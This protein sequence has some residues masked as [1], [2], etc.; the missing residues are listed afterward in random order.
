VLVA[1]AMH[2]GKD[3]EAAFLEIDRSLPAFPYKMLKKQLRL[4]DEAAFFRLLTRVLHRIDGCWTRAVRRVLLARKLHKAGIRGTSKLLC[5]SAGVQNQAAVLHDWAALA[6]EALRKILKKANKRGHE[7]QTVLITDHRLGFAR[8]W[9]RTEIEALG[10]HG[11]SPSCNSGRAMTDIDCPVCL[12]VLFKPVAPRS[13]GHAMCGP[14][15][16]HLQRR[17][18]ATCPKCRG[19]ID[20]TEAMPVLAVLAKAAEPWSVQSRREEEEAERDRQ[21]ALKYRRHI[22]NHPMLVLS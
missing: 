5:G 21:L 16:K 14:C 3:C 20:R 19:P 10:M 13:C 1:R 18:G 7:T 15:F 11:T 2:F 12:D 8:S 9:L 17:K 6:R 22:R 4:E